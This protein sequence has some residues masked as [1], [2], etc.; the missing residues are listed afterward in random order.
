MEKYS[1][2]NNLDL[3]SLHLHNGSVVDK[4]ANL[5]NEQTFRYLQKLNVNVAVAIQNHEDKFSSMELYYLA[6]NHNQFF[7]NKIYVFP[8]MENNISLNE[9]ITTSEKSVALNV[10]HGKNILLSAYRCGLKQAHFGAF[11]DASSE[12]GIEN[13][14]NAKELNA[15]CRIINFALTEP[16][17]KSS[18]KKIIG[19]CCKNFQV[20]INNKQIRDELNKNDLVKNENMAE[21]IIC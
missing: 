15:Y 18:I 3:I 21:D 6:K 13:W 9:V 5:R 16:D 12:K 4:H 10:E 19:L 20:S 1:K 11:A 2:I 8:A 14:E 7:D 17:Y